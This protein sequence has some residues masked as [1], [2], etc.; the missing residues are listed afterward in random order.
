[1]KYYFTILHCQSFFF[2]TPAFFYES[3]ANDQ[4]DFGLT[5]SVQLCTNV[6]FVWIP[7]IVFKDIGFLISLSGAKLLYLCLAEKTD[8]FCLYILNSMENIIWSRDSVILLRHLFV[9]CALR[10]VINII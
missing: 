1:M 4:Y 9:K 6:S 5:L 2:V 10:D 3:N 8:L 7:L